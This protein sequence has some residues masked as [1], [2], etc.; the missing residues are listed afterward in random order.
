MKSSTEHDL[1]LNL[2][3]LNFTI[4]SSE[5]DSYKLEKNLNL[6]NLS[7]RNLNILLLKLN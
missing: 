4:L 5:M 2:G 7:T 6:L 3:E 1:Y